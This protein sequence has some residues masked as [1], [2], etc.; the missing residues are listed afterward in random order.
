VQ[1]RGANIEKQRGLAVL[2]QGPI[3]GKGSQIG[4][5]LT[6]GGVALKPCTL[7]WLHN[8]FFEGGPRM[9]GSA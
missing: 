1:T 9:K 4:W 2:A 7:G 5:L 8:Y 3:C 6:R